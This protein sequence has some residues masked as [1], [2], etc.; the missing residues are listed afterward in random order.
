MKGAILIPKIQERI[1][2]DKKNQIILQMLADN[3]RTP[4]SKMS[5]KVKISK[6]AVL[7]RIRQMQEKK[8]ILEYISYY[9]LI[10]AGY[11]FHAIFLETNREDEA[12]F[13]ERIIQHKFST[14]AIKVA[15]K[16]NIFWMVFSKNQEHLNKIIS[17]VSGAMP[18]KDLRIS[19]IN[20]NYFDNYK[21]FVGSKK[22]LKEFKSKVKLNSIDAEILNSLKNNSKISLVKISEKCKLS[23][24]AIHQRIKKLIESG[25]ILKFF[26]NFNIFKLGFQPY[27]VLIKTNRERQKEVM[28]FIRKYKNTNGQYLLDSE[29]DIMC[30][31]VIKDVFELKEFTEKIN[32]LFKED[33]I[34]YEIYLI[35]EQFLNDFFPE[36]IYEDII[37][38]TKNSKSTNLTPQE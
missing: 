22:E 17:D 32:K 4:L 1:Q 5:K 12:K 9:N 34:D 29:Y 11:Q 35:I 28:N 18:I 30:M 2:I 20:E 26:T 37:N 13:V 38:K 31:L 33:V 8:I 15:S 36:G 27:I 21:L 16:F 25:V 24:E 14:T 10:R 3:S 7:Q 19:P 23:A 6:P